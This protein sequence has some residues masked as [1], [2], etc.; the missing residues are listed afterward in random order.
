LKGAGSELV[1]GVKGVYLIPKNEYQRTKKCH[2][3]AIGLGKGVL[4]LVF[5]PVA[6]I[7][8]TGQSLSQG[9]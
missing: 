2:Y 6:A 9:L 7:F 4:G 3:G 1:Q 8:R 5:S